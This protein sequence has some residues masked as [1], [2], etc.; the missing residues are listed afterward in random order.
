MSD[1]DII[2]T[3]A[4][5]IGSWLASYGDE[6][7]YHEPDAN[8]RA[9]LDQQLRKAS[10]VSGYLAAALRERYAIVELPEPVGNMVGPF[11]FSR[12]AGCECCPPEVYDTDTEV[13]YS[14]S[15]ARVEA[16]ALLAAS[17]AAEADQ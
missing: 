8:W 2:D 5:H 4:A 1:Q 13:S 11:R 15:E 6:Y 10:E 17:A 14:V 12:G 16:A 3:I 9:L 7:S